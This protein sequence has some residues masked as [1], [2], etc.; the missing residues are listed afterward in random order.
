VKARVRVCWFA[1]DNDLRAPD[2]PRYFSRESFDRHRGRCATPRATSLASAT[3]CLVST[4]LG[5]TPCFQHAFVEVFHS[6]EYEP[7]VVEN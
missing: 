6:A 4:Q 1:P 5:A 7:P 2:K 3:L